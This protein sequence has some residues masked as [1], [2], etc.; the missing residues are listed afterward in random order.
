MGAHA[1]HGDS[2]RL[3]PKAKAMPNSACFASILRQGATAEEG[4]KAVQVQSKRFLEIN[5]TLR[6][7]SPPTML[8]LTARLLQSRQFTTAYV[9]LLI[10][11]LGISTFQNRT[12]DMIGVFF[13][14]TAARALFLWSV[15]W[16]M[17]AFAPQAV[18][19]L[20]TGEPGGVVGSSTGLLHLQALPSREEGYISRLTGRSWEAIP[21]YHAIPL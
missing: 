14:R 6:I 12:A 18:H 11:F 16:W 17:T 2:L 4:Q 15:S 8:S 7:Q 5:W 10:P 19:D 1:T 13:S 9:V 3:R 21:L 20:R